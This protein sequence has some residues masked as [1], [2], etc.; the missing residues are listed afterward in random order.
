MTH[1]YKTKKEALS[2]A[3]EF[4]CIGAHKMPNGKYMPC[5]TH[6]KY[7][8]LS[9]KK[10]SSKSEKSEGEIDELVD[11]DGTFLN[12]KIPILD[13]HVHP[14]KTMDQ[15]VSMA[16]NVYDIFRMGYR[17]YFYEE[18]MSKVFGRE[19]DTDFMSYDETVDYLSNLLGIEDTK[20]KSE[21]KEIES[22]AEERAKEMGKIPG[23]K[24]KQR[25]FEKEID[26]KEDILVRKS[27]RDGDINKKELSTPKV[28][29]NNIKVL[30][31]QAE[32][33]GISI[34]EL[35]KMLKSE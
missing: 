8:E 14:K 33:M 7:I 24:K 22:D 25:L 20:S 32:T 21:K 28:I 19:E 13:P 10:N 30:K 3:T 31:K 4:G 1:E 34:N 17:R 26:V 11:R 15:T 23:K 6:G 2:K 16:R 5:R 27:K 12:S 35:I 29:K 9:R 18:D